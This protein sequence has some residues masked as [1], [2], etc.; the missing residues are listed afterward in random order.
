MEFV[1]ADKDG[2][3]HDYFDER[4]DAVEALCQEEREQPGITAGWMLLTYN[5]Q[6]EEVGEPEWADVLLSDRGEATSSMPSPFALATDSLAG[7]TAVLRSAPQDSWSGMALTTT[8][9]FSYRHEGAIDTHVQ[10]QGE[11]AAGSPRTHQVAA[12]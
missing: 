8:Y 1:W 6:G 10:P 11:M 12:F 3:S 9:A 4:R 5:D 7:F 2:K